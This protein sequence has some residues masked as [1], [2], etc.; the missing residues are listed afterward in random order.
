[1]A[2]AMPVRT[3][4]QD[5][6]SDELPMLKLQQNYDDDSEEKFE[7]PIVDGRTVEANLYRL[8]EF[9]KAAEELTYNTGDGLFRNFC[10][11]LRGTITTEWDMV[12]NDMGFANMQNKSPAHFEQCV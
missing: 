10:K 6:D 1:M 9:F 12:I 3:L 4:T 8:N 2:H 11:V 7:I 5:F